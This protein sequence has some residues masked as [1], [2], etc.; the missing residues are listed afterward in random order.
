VIIG[1]IRENVE[2]NMRESTQALKAEVGSY[3][4]GYTAITR[5]KKDI[6]LRSYYFLAETLTSKT[7]TWSDSLSFGSE[8]IP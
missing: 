6:N 8:H 5:R 4:R 2:A 7:L 1:N 3:V